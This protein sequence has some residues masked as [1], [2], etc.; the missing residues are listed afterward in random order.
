MLTFIF[1]SVIIIVDL[2]M[3][4]LKKGKTSTYGLAENAMKTNMIVQAF[5]IEVSEADVV[6]RVKEVWVAD[7]NKVKDIKSLVMYVKPEEKKVYYVINDEV[8]GELDV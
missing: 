8:N 1:F 2:E 7:G 6:A 5:G 3:R 4:N